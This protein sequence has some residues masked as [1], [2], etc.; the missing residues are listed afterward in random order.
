MSEEL[1]AFFEE[2]NKAIKYNTQ[3]LIAEMSKSTSLSRPTISREL[4]DELFNLFEKHAT[5][6]KI[7]GLISNTYEFRFLDGIRL[8]IKPEASGLISVT[9]YELEDNE[10]P[11]PLGE[12]TEDGLIPFLKE[13]LNYFTA[14]TPLPISIV[15]RT[16]R[17][18]NNYGYSL[19]RIL[20][21]AVTLTGEH[22]AFFSNGDLPLISIGLHTDNTLKF[23][24]AGNEDEGPY[25]YGYHFNLS[26]NTL[27]Y[28]L[29]RFLTAYI[30]P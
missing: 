14:P 21:R 20:T 17:L 18:L 22:A 4:I 29:A 8:L 30:D 9:R 3:Q 27:E 7:L 25:G 2:A 23:H 1:K 12:F 26:A 5:Y 10:Y 15:K 11:I 6:A 24:C 19:E 13:I 28:D 16:A